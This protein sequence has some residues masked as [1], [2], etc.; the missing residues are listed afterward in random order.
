MCAKMIGNKL[1]FD[2]VIAGHEWIHI[3]NFNYSG[4]VIDPDKYPEMGF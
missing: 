3:M 4:R 1:V 2:P